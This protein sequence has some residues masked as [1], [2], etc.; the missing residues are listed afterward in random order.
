[1]PKYNDYLKFSPII[2]FFLFF[3]VSCAQLKEWSDEPEEYSSQR[4]KVMTERI[5]RK[6]I[7][8]PEGSTILDDNSQFNVGNIFSGLGG[9]GS[10]NYMADSIVFDVALDKVSF[11]PLASVDTNAGIII[12]DWYSLNDGDSRIKIN[13]RIADQEMTDESLSVSLFSQSLE[14]DRWVDQGIN[15]EQSLKIKNS[16]LSTARSLKIASEL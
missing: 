9:G 11:M 15:N 6:D 14:G 1:M 4:E 7:N 10:V 16:I 5:E 12:T 3:A 2:L 8:L 13:I